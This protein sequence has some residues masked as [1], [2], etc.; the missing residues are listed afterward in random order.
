MDKRIIVAIDGPAGAGKSTI[1]KEIARRM[2]FLYIDSGAMYRAVALLALQNSIPLDDSL[3]LAALAEN[4]EIELSAGTVLL[5]GTDVSAAIRESHISEA[6]SRVSKIAAVRRAMVALQRD[7][8]EASSVVME[9]RDIGTVV[10]PEAQVKIYLDASP[11]IRAKRR[12]EQ[13]GGDYETVL[14]E[15]RD[16]DDRDATRSDSPLRQ[17][18]DAVFLDSSL[19]SE[20]QIIEAVLKI[21]REKTSNG[22]GVTS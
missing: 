8:A 16:R 11:E 4:A 18:E 1:S 17:A 21:V 15:I 10:F 12:V 9:G 13:F 22:K 19:F 2:G 6:A 5:N 20:Q 3:K 14:A 7:Y